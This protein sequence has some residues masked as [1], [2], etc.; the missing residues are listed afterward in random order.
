MKSGRSVADDLKR[1]LADVPT[2]AIFVSREFWAIFM[3][4]V[5]F[6]NHDRR[7]LKR[8]VNKAVRG[9]RRAGIA[10]EIICPAVE[11]EKGTTPKCG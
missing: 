5:E 10:D 2:A 8:E 1:S 4:H 11:L 6:R 3:A 9:I 7:R